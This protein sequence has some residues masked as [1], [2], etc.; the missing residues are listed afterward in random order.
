MV[1]AYAILTASSMVVLLFRKKGIF[2]G[3]ALVFSGTWVVEQRRW[4][5]DPWCWCCYFI[6]LSSCWFT[7]LAK[8][9]MLAWSLFGANIRWSHY[10]GSKEVA[11]CW[12]LDA[13]CCFCRKWTYVS[14]WICKSSTPF[15]SAI[16][17]APT[18]RHFSSIN[19]ATIY[20]SLC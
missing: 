2:C 6:Q 20:A 17:I 16:E 8:D 13:S 12:S 4:N 3:R 5:I 11:D 9:S 14:S 18:L 7:T 1:W 10:L 15:A 19:I